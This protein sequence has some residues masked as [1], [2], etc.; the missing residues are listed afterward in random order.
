MALPSRNL[1]QCASLFLATSGA[2]ARAWLRL[3]GLMASM[4]DVIKFCRLRM[5][6]IQFH[7]LS[8]YRPSRNT[9]SH[10]V[11]TSAWL[12]P[13]LR[14]WLDDANLLGGSSFL[15]AP[16]VIDC[17]N[18]RSSVGLGG[19]PGPTPGGRVLG[20]RAQLGPH[21][22]LELLAV[23]YDL[24]CFRR[25]VVGQVVLVQSDNTTVVSYINRQGGTRSPQ[26]CAHTWELLHWCM[27]NEVSLTAIHLPGE[28][29]VTADALSRGW[30]HPTEW[31][32]RPQVAQLMFQLIDRPHVDLFASSNNHQLPTYCSEGRSGCPVGRASSVCFPPD[33][34]SLKLLSPNWS[35]RS[36][37]S[38]L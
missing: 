17:H 26:L 30:I 27:H 3:L 11:P 25:V 15:Q 28:E 14:W 19:Y 16:T 32:L 1:K 29:N 23:T 34:A 35:S 2:P 18:G 8:F 33:L 13:H 31:T 9:I 6:P 4:V 12:D 5:R 38:S 21:N 7:L 24:E 36:A 10:L 20:P 37:K 22:V